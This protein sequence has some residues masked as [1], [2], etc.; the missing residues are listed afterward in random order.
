MFVG[1]LHWRDEPTFAAASTC[2]VDG[3]SGH[4]ED[5]PGVVLAPSFEVASA[6]VRDHLGP[7]VRRVYKASPLSVE[8]QVWTSLLRTLQ[9]AGKELGARPGAQISFHGKVAGG[10]LSIL[11][12]EKPAGMSLSFDQQRA[13]HEVA[14]PCP[15]HAP[16]SEA[17][18]ARARPFSKLLLTSEACGSLHAATGGGE[19]V[20]MASL[21]LGFRDDSRQGALARYN[22]WQGFKKD[23]HRLGAIHVA[24]GGAALPSVSL[25]HDANQLVERAVEVYALRLPCDMVALHQ[26]VDLLQQGGL[27]ATIA[28]FLL[29]QGIQIQRPTQT[30]KLTETGVVAEVCAVG[31]D[32]GEVVSDE[33]WGVP[34][35]A[36][37][38]SLWHER[39]RRFSAV[40]VE[41]TRGRH[42]RRLRRWLGGLTSR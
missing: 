10:L 32:R 35:C 18:C 40:R 20:H 4:W 5:F 7:D 26:L 37:G 28:N 2:I 33:R 25:Q 9:E 38:V 16:W 23:A 13:H 8:G 34:V 42:L 14:L 36:R 24:G 15:L 12:R 27:F 39:E 1:V 41:I 30:V 22:P 29:D 17:Q 19:L 11:S 6:D 3:R 21:V 31:R